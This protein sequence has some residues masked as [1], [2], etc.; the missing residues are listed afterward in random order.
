MSVPE[1]REHHYLFSHTVLVDYAFR[2]TDKLVSRLRGE[3]AAQAIAHLWGSTAEMLDPG[4]ALEQPQ[5]AVSVHPGP[6]EGLT[7]IL[8]RFEG[9]VEPSECYCVA[10][11]Y[12]PPA[13]RFL[14]LKKKSALRLFV[15]ERGFDSDEGHPR[16]YVAEYGA[17]RER[18][19]LGDLPDRDSETFLA[20]IADLHAQQ[21]EVGT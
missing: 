6:I 11:V 17:G 9:P 14:F 13:A 2:H 16:A 3:Q 18:T 10:L 5:I 1:P 7:T 20:L 8:L 21:A 19:R 4:E 15:L 12:R